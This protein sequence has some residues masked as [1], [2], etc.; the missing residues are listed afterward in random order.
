[1][2]TNKE[3]P[4]PYSGLEQ[5]T[6]HTA[7]ANLLTIDFG[8]ACGRIVLNHLCIA[9]EKLVE[10]FYPL[11]TRLKV[12]QMLWSAVHESERPSYGKRIQDCKIVP[13]ILTVVNSDDIK[14]LKNNSKS[15]ELQTTVIKRL[16]E[17]AHQ[18]H[19]VLTEADLRAIT[20]LSMTHIS[21][22]IRKYESKTDTIIPRRGTVHDIGRSLTHKRIV[23]YKYF[24][25]RYST[26]RIAR[27]TNHS[28]ND[29]ERY[30][31]D[32]K[33]VKYCLLKNMTA[34]EI[35]IILKMSDSLVNE[36]IQ[37]ISS[38]GDSKKSKNLDYDLLDS[39]LNSGI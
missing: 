31:H 28:L 24:V 8:I 6:F 15:S 35:A 10:D 20:K 2:I 33:R 30:I 16:C 23:C 17:E 4:S 19:G 36:Y 21:L 7:L 38:F 1:M 5:K 37:L 39:K 32:Y 11:H 14:A 25:Q 3:K 13:V 22:L 18:Q 27:E 9:I 12:G 29:I 26:P 34:K